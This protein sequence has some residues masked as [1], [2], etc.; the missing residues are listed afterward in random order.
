MP[1]TRAYIKRETEE[2]KEYLKCAL[3]PPV[4]VEPISLEISKYEG[5]G[6]TGTLQ[7]KC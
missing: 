1:K 4:K 5:N 7:C 3:Y 2:S 6:S